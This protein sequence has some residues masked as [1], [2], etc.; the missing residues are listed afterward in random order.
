MLQVREHPTPMLQEQRCVIE[1]CDLAR[2]Q[3]RFVNVVT[4]GD[5]GW[6]DVDGA[7]AVLI[8]GAGAFSATETHHFTAR[9]TDVVAELIARDRPVL[10]S[11]WGHQFL[12]GMLGS[13]VIKDPDR[14]EIG[15]YDI[16]LT[17]AG[18]ADPL[19]SALPRR[20]TVHLGHHDRVETLGPQWVEL[21][22]SELCPHQAIRL[23]GKP[24]YGTQFHSEMN[25]DRFQERLEVYRADYAPD[26]EFFNRVIANLRPSTE[27]DRLLARFL[28]L[29]A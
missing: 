7:H 26:A 11:C 23:I 18:A 13:T 28:D 5:F 20:F 25:E 9:L 12:A 8:G 22:A 16:A 6:A 2:D 4:D 1:R 19:T 21:A 17:D 15:S 27:A 14:G 3:I 24:V 10:G 29:Y